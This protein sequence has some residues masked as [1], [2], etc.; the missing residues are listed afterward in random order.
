MNHALP[1]FDEDI[2]L[3]FI[4]R[5]RRKLPIDVWRSN[6][7]G[8]YINQ[9]SFYGEDDEVLRQA[10]TIQ[11]AVEKFKRANPDKKALWIPYYDM[12]AGS[13]LLAQRIAKMSEI[14]NLFDYI[15]IQPGFFFFTVSGSDE[16]EETRHRIQNMDAI[17][18]GSI[19]NS[20]VS[21]YGEQ[22][23]MRPSAAH[24][25]AEMEIQ[26]SYFSTTR[27]TRGEALDRYSHYL[28]LGS[29][30]KDTSPLVFYAS[31]DPHLSK[32]W[33][34]YK[35]Y[36]AGYLDFETV[37][38]RLDARVTKYFDYVFETR[39][40]EEFFKQYVKDLYLAA[41]PA[42]TD[43]SFDATFRA[44]PVMTALWRFEKQNGIEDLYMYLKEHSLPEF[45]VEL[46]LSFNYL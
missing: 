46:V 23:N 6:I 15:T 9:E 20:V 7:R 17:R 14:P 18:H 35:F 13:V 19:T 36:D 44:E 26:N 12:A 1:G 28:M 39:A 25:G 10:D 2:W 4:S 40:K 21:R 22:L 24:M 45:M 30:I 32:E 33:I 16:I 29:E 27:E 3:D 37:K 42:H 11:R 34:I 41:D 5:V 31:G 43:E 38:K 8:I